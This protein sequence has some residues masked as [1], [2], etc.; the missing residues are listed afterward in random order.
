MFN[1]I[2]RIHLQCLMAAVAVMVMA[3]FLAGFDSERHVTIV[4]DGQEK[5]LTT[6]TRR[7]NKIIAE[8]GFVLEDGD[9]YKMNTPGKYAQE[10]S[11]IEVVRGVPF[12]VVIGESVKDYKSA[13]ATIGEA[14]KDRGVK[15]KE[16]TVYPDPS[17]ALAKDME[18][19]VMK[20]NEELIFSDEHIEQAITYEE[21]FSKEFGTEE[22]K[23]EGKHGKASLVHKRVV[24]A[25]GT[26]SSVQLDRKVVE[27]PEAKVIRKGMAQSVLTP[28]GYKRYTRMMIGNASA[29]SHTGGRTASGVWPRRG[30]IATDTDVI[31][32]GTKMYIP[33]YGM[34]EAADRGSAIIG[35][36]ID[37]FFET[38]DEACDWGRRN[39]EVY[40]LAE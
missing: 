22:V 4:A 7:P 18:I 19:Y 37:L 35:N 2:S 39:V 16:G 36:K 10:G 38:Y 26:S 5:Q 17:D 34:A 29:Y 8:A 3:L 6:T 40:I 20:E 13:K 21:D 31:P 9:D 25:D 27:E 11:R 28:Q 1:K 32:F 23:H 14:L 24:H 12:K 15:Y 33:G 30:L